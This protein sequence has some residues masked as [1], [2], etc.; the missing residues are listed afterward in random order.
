MAAQHGQ[1]R[2][3]SSSNARQGLP[4]EPEAQVVDTV[5]LCV[6]VSGPSSLAMRL[7]ADVAF[8]NCALTC[9][10]AHALLERRE[11]EEEWRKKEEEEEEVEKAK[12]EAVMALGRLQQR[13][14][15]PVFAS[16]SAAASNPSLDVLARSDHLTSC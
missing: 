5:T 15:L 10:L 13:T 4:S 14:A 16:S 6:A 3:D 12:E 8:D 2:E 9:L 11:Q 7:A 1:G